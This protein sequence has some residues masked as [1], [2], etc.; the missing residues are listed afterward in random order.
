MQVPFR[1]SSTCIN[2]ELLTF[3]YSGW[4]TMQKPTEDNAPARCLAE[5]SKKKP[6][7]GCVCFPA[8]HVQAHAIIRQMNL[9]LSCPH[10]WMDVYEW[11]QMV[12]TTWQRF[13][14]LLVRE[15]KTKKSLPSKERL[16]G[17]KTISLGIFIASL[18]LC[19][20]SLSILFCTWKLNQNIKSEL[21]SPCR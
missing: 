21:L 8:E 7:P 4:T 6:F 5:S 16:Q 11:W 15:V 19:L 2:Y 20:L 3:W 1:Q 10:F 14:S 17:I 13:F 9:I 18:R 12:N